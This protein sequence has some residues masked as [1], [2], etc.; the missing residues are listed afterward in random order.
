MLGQARP[1]LLPGVRSFSQGNYLI[2]FRYE[3]NRLEVV[4]VI[5]GH[6]D[7]AAHFARD[8]NS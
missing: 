7:I 2:F 1:D 5:E 4:N 8:R 3:E 6:R